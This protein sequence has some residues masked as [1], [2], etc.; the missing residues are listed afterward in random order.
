M[1]EKATFSISPRAS[2]RSPQ[3]NWYYNIVLI[4]KAQNNNIEQETG[5]PNVLSFTKVYN[6]HQETIP[7]NVIPKL[8]TIYQKTSAITLYTLLVQSNDARQDIFDLFQIIYRLLLS[9]LNWQ[10]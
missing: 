7:S 3:I 10:I 6:F 9:N 2:P 8:L 4:T 5:K 1:E